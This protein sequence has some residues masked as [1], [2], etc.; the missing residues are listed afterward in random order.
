MGRSGYTSEDKPNV[1]IR[2]NFEKEWTAS[3]G[4]STVLAGSDGGDCSWHEVDGIIESCR[5]LLAQWER[6]LVFR[7]GIYFNEFDIPLRS[8]GIYNLPM[9]HGKPCIFLHPPLHP[10]LRNSLQILHTTKSPLHSR[11]GKTRSNNP[12]RP[13]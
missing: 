6:V 10:S 4:R 2:G 11:L 5:T 13:K 1:E 8:F 7:C 3:L 12:I 9:K